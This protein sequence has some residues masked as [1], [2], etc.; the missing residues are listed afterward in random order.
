MDSKLV[1][2]QLSGRWQVKH[3]DMKPLAARA[4]GL[5]K[6]FADASLTWVA[7]AQ[8]S[9]CRPAGQRGDG[10]RTGRSGLASRG[11]LA[12]PDATVPE[13]GPGS[14]RR[15]ARAV[16]DRSHEGAGGPARG[17]DLGR[18][19]AVRR[20]RGCA[21]DQQG[22]PAGIVGRRSGQGPATEHR[23]D[24][25]TAAVPADRQCDRRRRGRAG[26]RRTPICWTVCW[27]SGRDCDPPRS[28]AAGPSEFAIWRS[29]PDASPPGGESFNQIRERVTPLLAEVV[30]LYR[31]HTV[32][33]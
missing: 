11:S 19:R 1:I 26:G 18:R 9:A 7:R 25:A 14:G 6:G 10:R 5:L 22:A 21:A 8:N 20:P 28:R 15:A 32:V 24:L 16:A 29:D 31:G 30:R 2:E 27:A 23:A 4:S 12:S 3:P 13:N 17:D 33:W